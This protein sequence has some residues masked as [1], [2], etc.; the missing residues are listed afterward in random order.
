MSL[1]H[2]NLVIFVATQ[3]TRYNPIGQ[4]MCDRTMIMKD[5]VTSCEQD[6]NSDQLFLYTR[7]YAYIHCRTCNH[8]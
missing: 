4:V 3:N 6:R 1:L 5:H 7:F 2:Q 8:V